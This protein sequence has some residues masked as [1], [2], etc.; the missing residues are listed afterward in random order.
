MFDDDFLT[1]RPG[2]RLASSV[3]YIA[4]SQLVSCRP[5]SIVLDPGLVYVAGQTA[6]AKDAITQLQ[7]SVLSVSNGDGQVFIPVLI[8]NH[9]TLVVVHQS[10]RTVRYYDSCGAS[11]PGAFQVVTRIL[12]YTQGGWWTHSH[13]KCLIQMN[14]NDCGVSVFLNTMHLLHNPDLDHITIQ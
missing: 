2:E 6:L 7:A 1:I 4:M 11:S 12:P 8:N 10:H 5:G 13:L 9:Y 3:L 14:G